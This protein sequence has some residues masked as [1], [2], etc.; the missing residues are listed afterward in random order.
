[1]RTIQLTRGYVTLI[2]DAD[3]ERVAE[4]K[5]CAFCT[6]GKVYAVSARKEADGTRLLLHRFLLNA[7]ADREVDH[8]DGNGLHNF[9]SNLRLVT[10]QQNVWNT[11][12]KSN[13]TSGEKGVSWDKA[14]GKWKASIAA[15]GHQ[16]TIGRYDTIE[17]AII[18]R[19]AAADRLHGE[20]AA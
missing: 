12:R 18:A 2:D 6:R 13:N 4:R 8:K 19:R 17:E 9:R 3:Y 10:H 1:M 16:Y 20:Y 11:R 14:R 5:W 7:P 15:H